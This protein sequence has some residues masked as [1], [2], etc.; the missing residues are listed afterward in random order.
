MCNCLEK[1]SESKV[2]DCRGVLIPTTK[3]GIMLIP[4][5]Y[6]SGCETDMSN[7]IMYVNSAKFCPICGERYNVELV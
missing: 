6:V 7:G 3:E 2:K 1:L 4:I 5:K